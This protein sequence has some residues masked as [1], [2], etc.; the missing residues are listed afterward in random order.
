MTIEIGTVWQPVRKV[1][2]PKTD[3][4]RHDLFM[5]YVSRTLVENAPWLVHLLDAANAVVMAGPGEF[6]FSTQVAEGIWHEIPELSKL[7][8]MKPWVE[9]DE[10]TQ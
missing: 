7:I 6:T 4:E 10:I 2:K 3:Q 8:A 5:A 1:P 9:D